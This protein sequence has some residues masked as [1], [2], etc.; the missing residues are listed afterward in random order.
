[1]KNNH[2][3]T[4]PRAKYKAMCDALTDQGIFIAVHMAANKWYQVHVNF[5]VV[6]RY[7]QRRSCNKYIE[8]IYN[9]RMGIDQPSE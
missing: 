4:D 5:E 1:M 2:N 9:E 6:R 3:P 7:K 8:R